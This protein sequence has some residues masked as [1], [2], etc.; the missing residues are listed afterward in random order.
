MRAIKVA[1]NYHAAPSR[2]STR[3]VIYA[4]STCGGEFGSSNLPSGAVE[5]RDH[6]SS[7]L[8]RLRSSRLCTFENFRVPFP[9]VDPSI[10]E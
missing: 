5:F 2:H 6:R 7:Y 3:E 9:K 1:I 4:K 8:L 10:F